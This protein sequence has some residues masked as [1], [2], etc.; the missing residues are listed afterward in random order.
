MKI[1]AFSDVTSWKGYEK[2]VDE[3]HPDVVTLAGDL[4][5]D[6]FASFWN[7]AVEPIPEFQME[8]ERLLGRFNAV[9]K[10]KNFYH[11][12][13]K[14]GDKN[15]NEKWF[16]ELTNAL[17]SLRHNFMDTKEFLE[18]RKKMHVDKFYKFLRY[19]GKKSEV[20][21][22]KGDHDNDFEGDYDS[23]KIN[24]ISGCKEISGKSMQ[25]KEFSFLGL[26]FNETHYLKIL[27]PEIETFK[28]KID[29]VITHC[30]QNRVSLLSK[31]KPKLIIRGHFGSGKYLV[32]GIPSVF[33]A[34]ASMYTVIEISKKDVPKILQYRNI[35]GKIELMKKGSCRPWLSDK[36]EFEM[37]KWLN[38]Y[39]S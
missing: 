19:A 35:F 10:A 39:P 23:E 6:G 3:I 15:F 31:F 33:T 20:L 21:V 29:I 32:N 8:K 1:L 11:Y 25:I 18:N 37:Y 34:P 2:L 5:S 4:T 22:I 14:K 30:E 26:G 27:K 12:T 38:P 28:R 16:D 9:E 24:K 36:S 17:H 7:D 13:K